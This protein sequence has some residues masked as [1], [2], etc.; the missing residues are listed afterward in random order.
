[1]A[2]YRNL[3]IQ[4]QFALEVEYSDHFRRGRGNHWVKCCDLYYVKCLVKWL[5]LSLLLLESLFYSLECELFCSP[6][7]I[8]LEHVTVINAFTQHPNPIE[9][10]I[11]NLVFKSRNLAAEITWFIESDRICQSTKAGTSTNYCEVQQRDIQIH[12]YYKSIF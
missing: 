8:M 9:L 3:D 7:T 4:V 5:K 11:N 2:A 12:M 10:N 6:F 1:M